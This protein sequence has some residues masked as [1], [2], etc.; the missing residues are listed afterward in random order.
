MHS[1]NKNDKK[2][3]MVLSLS[4]F[5]ALLG[6][7]IITPLLPIYASELG[8]GG[9]LLGVI[10]G[11]FSF[12]RTGAMLI[13]GELAE[14]CEKKKLLA[15]GL[16]FYA[17]SSLG[18]L[19][20]H[21][22]TS[23][24]L[25]RFFHGFGSA[26]VVPVA[27]AIGAESAPSNEE[28]AFLGTLQT[29]LFLGIGSGPLISGFLTDNFGWNSSFY[30]MT[31]MT[32]IALLLVMLTLPSEPISSKSARKKPE[33]P[34]PMILKMLKDPTLKVVVIFHYC[35][36][37]ARGSLL[38]L[39]P[40][41]ASQLNM[42][43]SQIG[44]LVSLNS[45]ATAICQ[46]FFGKLSDNKGKIRVILLGGTLS[47]A[48]FFLLPLSRGFYSLAILSSIF[49]FGRSA[50]SPALSALAAVRGKVFGSGRTM[51]LYNMAFSAGMMTG[52]VLAGFLSQAAGM[53]NALYSVGIILS[54]SLFVFLPYFNCSKGEVHSIV[55]GS[56]R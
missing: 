24:L 45:I 1:I 53:A 17:L 3:L 27:M 16:C 4:L 12:S 25:V 22:S 47:A 46:R 6:V 18:Y 30:A 51:G 42:T 52:P 43:L 19:H 21:D 38:M 34:F 31:S 35:S 26:L 50:S 23:L 5:C 40:I 54:L 41:F 33:N 56:D 14:R 15:T 28:G 7:G 44:I 2:I 29:S 8:I 11:I 9:P 32:T 37:I 55:P 36:A 49:G 39:I 20:A 48:V 10:L 13:S